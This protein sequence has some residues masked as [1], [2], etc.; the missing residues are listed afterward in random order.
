MRCRSR[1]SPQRNPALATSYTEKFWKV[2]DGLQPLRP[3]LSGTRPTVAR[4]VLCL[5]GLTRNSRDFEDLAP[6]LQQQLS[7]H[8]P[9]CARPRTSGA[10]SQ[11]AELPAGDLS[12]GHPRV[13]SMPLDAQRVAII[14]TSMGGMLAMM[15]AVGSRDRVS[16]VVLERHGAGS[17]SQRARAH[18]GLCRSPAAAQELGRGDCTNSN[19]V[20]QCLA[21]SVH[22]A[23]VGARRAAAIEKMS[24]ARCTSM[25]IR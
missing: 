24:R 5:H 18:Q 3:S 19:D 1:P 9:G 13:C 25:P 17:R 8:R 16:G 2:I 4:A 12:S 21:E 10:R 11:S 7:S 14:G 20:R 22:R 15:M 6:H 23:L